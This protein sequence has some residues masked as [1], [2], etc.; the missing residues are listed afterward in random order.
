MSCVIFNSLPLYITVDLLNIF[1]AGI[2]AFLA[3]NER[4]CLWPY[5]DCV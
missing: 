5:S 2:S 1:K 3:L 4:V